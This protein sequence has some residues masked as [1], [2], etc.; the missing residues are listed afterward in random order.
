MINHNPDINLHLGFLHQW[1]VRWFR[2]FSRWE[3]DEV[4]NQAYISALELLENK[5]APE[6]GAVTT[7]LNCFLGGKVYYAYGKSMGWRKREGKWRIFIIDVKIEDIPGAQIDEHRPEYPPSLTEKEKKVV[8]MKMDGH[9]LLEIAK[10]FGYKSPN[11][12]RYWF[13]HHIRP[14]FHD[15]G[16]FL[17]EH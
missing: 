9:S 11:T 5:Y 7:F 1:T 4:Y 14:K 13:K 6:K 15:S 10:E 12:V 3:F 16:I 2:F 8:E 17:D